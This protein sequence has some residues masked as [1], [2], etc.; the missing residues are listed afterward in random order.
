MLI[1]LT[2]NCLAYI[3]VSTNPVTLNKGQRSSK[4]CTLAVLTG[5]YNPTKFEEFWYHSLRKTANVKILDNFE[6]TSIISPWIQNNKVKLIYMNNFHLGYTHPKLHLYQASGYRDMQSVHF[7]VS[8]TLWPWVKVKGHQKL[9]TLVVLIEG[10]NHTKF[11]E[12]RY[13]SLRKS[14]NV[15]VSDQH[16]CASIISPWIQNGRTKLVYM[17][18][19]W[20][21]LHIYQVSSSWHTRFSRYWN[22]LFFTYADPVT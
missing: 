4:W 12:I 6:R 13:H 21:T 1:R 8:L 10:N 9:H 17:T 16:Q 2:L 14:P 5:V 20:W 19:I 22:C 3:Y 18:Y 11:E 15:K 7:S